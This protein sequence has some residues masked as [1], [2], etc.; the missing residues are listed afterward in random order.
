MNPILSNDSKVIQMERLNFN[1]MLIFIFFLSCQTDNFKNLE[2]EGDLYA[3]N[4][5]MLKGGVP[6]NV[7]KI[8]YRWYI[9]SSINGEWEMLDGI[10]TDQIVLLTSYVDNFLKGE[11]EYILDSG[12]LF[13]K[14]VISSHPVKYKGNSNTDWFK[15]A[16]WGV[17]V[18]YLKDNIVPEGGSKEWNEAVNSFNVKRFAEQV[19]S[20]G[21]RFVMFTLGQNSG[22]YCSPNFVYDSIVGVNPGELCSKRDLPMD[23]V[24][25]LKE[26]DIP[27]ILYLPANPLSRPE[28]GLHSM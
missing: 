13:K 11:I 9:S 8:S 3:K 1:L 6:A 19:N 18:H 12:E 26:Y 10:Y 24:K 15:E 23:L 21:A 17:M 5:I 2:M 20:A 16:G 14:T 27:L 25:A 22:Y 4:V 28:I 7:K